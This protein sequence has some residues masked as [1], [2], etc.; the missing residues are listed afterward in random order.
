MPYAKCPNCGT[1]SHYKL[2]PEGA[3]KWKQEHATAISK[4][5]MASLKCFLCWKDLHELDVVEVIAPPPGN[6]EV[7]AGDTGAIVAVLSAQNGDI[8]YEVECVL[9]SGATK[10]VCAFER[11]QLK[12]IK[13]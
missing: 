4:G 7:L 13:V 5:E 8:G 6:T 11:S 1:I 12:A 2:T 10:W 9:K 3:A